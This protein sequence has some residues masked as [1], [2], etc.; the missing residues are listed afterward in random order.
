MDD[1]NQCN[2]RS[3][4]SSVLWKK[5]SSNVER[6][7]IPLA[8]C[9][10]QKALGKRGPLLCVVRWAE[11]GGRHDAS[12]NDLPLDVWSIANQ[13]TALLKLWYTDYDLVLIY[14]QAAIIN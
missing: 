6:F 5:Y 8:K 3:F 11:S 13:A 7:I 12:W 14:I 4:Y 10:T 1:E 2:I 9:W